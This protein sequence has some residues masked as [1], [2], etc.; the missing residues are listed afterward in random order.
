MSDTLPTSTATPLNLTKPRKEDNNNQV[1]IL[2]ININNL[3]IIVMPI[4]FK[5]IRRWNINNLTM[6]NETFYFSWNDFKNKE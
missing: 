6:F 2:I 1:R 4:S 5:I 3:N